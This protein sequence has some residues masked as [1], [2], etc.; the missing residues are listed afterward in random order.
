MNSLLSS[1]PHRFSD[2]VL[3]TAQMRFLE[4]GQSLSFC[5]K[6]QCGLD[7]LPSEVIARAAGLPGWRVFRI[8]DT[9]TICES[10]HAC[11]RMELQRRGVGTGCEIALWATSAE[12]GNA[13]IA[14]LQQVIGVKLGDHYAATVEWWHHD[15][16]AGALAFTHAPRFSRASLRHAAVARSGHH[17]AGGQR[18]RGRRGDR[19]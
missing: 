3:Y 16:R 11:I 10:T 5:R 14:E 6:F 17:T 4:A 18:V 2:H 19:Q 13:T 7:A 8:S 15:G 9:R 1:E 12:T